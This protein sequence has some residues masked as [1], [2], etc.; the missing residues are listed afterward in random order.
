[1]LLLLHSLLLLL[2]LHGAHAAQRLFALDAL[3]LTSLQY[4]FVF[5]T[6]LAALDV[7]P[8]ECGDDGVGVALA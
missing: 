2:E 8:I 3:F 5:Y 6:K 1:M 7:K 4:F